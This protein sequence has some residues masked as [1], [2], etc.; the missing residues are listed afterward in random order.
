M[1]AT[2]SFDSEKAKLLFFAD[3]VNRAR[4]VVVADADVTVLPQRVV[5]QIVPREIT[6]HVPIT[7]VCNR[8]NFPALA[9]M[10]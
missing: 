9:M 3:L 7:P 10:K 5:G 4:R 1:Q 2:L 6:M 8:M